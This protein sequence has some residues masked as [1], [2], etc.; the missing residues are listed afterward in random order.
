MYS[1]SSLGAAF[2]LLFS[3]FGELNDMTSYP[4]LLI[5]AM[6]DAMSAFLLTYKFEPDALFDLILLFRDV[7][8]VRYGLPVLYI[9]ILALYFCV[10]ENTTAA[11]SRCVQ[12]SL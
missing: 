11:I 2:P 8:T 12:P 5:V 7:Q 9:V 3:V 6:E 1:C 4:L 10:L